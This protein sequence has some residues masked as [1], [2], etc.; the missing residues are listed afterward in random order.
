M[1]DASH[2]ADP[3]LEVAAERKDGLLNGEERQHVQ[4]GVVDDRLERE[5]VR[6]APGLGE[7][8]KD[9]ARV[10]AVVFVVFVAVF[11]VVV[12]VVV[13]VVAVGATAPPSPPPDPPRGDGGSGG[14][15]SPLQ[16]AAEAQ[17]LGSARE[18][19]EDAERGADE[20][21]AEGFS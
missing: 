18:G 8:A 1:P 13:A 5:T 14:G 3:P 2:P 21:A 19:A 12:F 10:A 17:G 9:E 11:V 20:R 15:L 7:A 6:V 16:P 4:R